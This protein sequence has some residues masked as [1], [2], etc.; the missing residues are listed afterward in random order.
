MRRSL[1]IIT[2]TG[3][4]AACGGGGDSNKDA[5]VEAIAASVQQDDAPFTE[6]QAT[7]IASGMVDAIGVD[8]IEEAGVTPDDIANDDDDSQ[9][10]KVT[11]DI[12]EEQ[13]SDI[14]DVIFGGECFS[15]GEVLV[16]QM[17]DDGPDLSDDQIE[18]IGDQFAQNEAF[19]Q[20]FVDSLITGEDNPDV[21]AALGDIFSIFGECDIDLGDLGG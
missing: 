7:C 5:Y 21:D 11:K 15:F 13:A 10:E 1:A 12:S 4:L 8:T 20:A 17:G 6:E 18:C 19:K 14:V 9:F 16:S 3:L 2:L